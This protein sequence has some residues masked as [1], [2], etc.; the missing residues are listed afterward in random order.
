MIIFFTGTPGSGKTYDA[1]RKI[2]K[3]LLKRRVVYTN[4][5]GMEDPLCHE[6]IKS[7]LNLDDDEFAHLFR[8]LGT[9]SSVIERFWEHCEAESL[10]ILDEVQ[11]YFSNRDWQS[12]KNKDFGNWASTHRHHGYDLV[13]ITQAAERVDSAVRALTEWNY[14]Y[15]KVNFFGGAVQKKYLRYC[16][17]GEDTNGTPL[18]KNV[19]TYDPKIFLCYK[20]YVSKDTKELSIMQHVNVLKHPVFIAIPVALGICLYMVIFKSSIGKGDL[21]GSDAIQ[22]KSLSLISDANASTQENSPAAESNTPVSADSITADIPSNPVVTK[23]IMLN[24]LQ[25]IKK[26]KSTYQILFDHFIYT[27]EDFPYPVSFQ[28]KTLYADIPISYF[29]AQEEES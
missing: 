22:E 17:A 3:N 13:L 27:L 14:I 29:D 10:I 7:L 8:H 28:N 26:G 9:D 2:L 21:F 15:R 6:A 12:A 18:S 1:V 20:S 23:R 4:I 16:Y 11:K 25:V 5:D 24:Y 19:R